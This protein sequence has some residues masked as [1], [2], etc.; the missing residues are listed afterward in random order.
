MEREKLSKKIRFEVFKRDSF[1]CQYCG[2]KAPD[3]VLEVDH[4][5]PVAEGGKNDIFNLITSCFDCNRGKGKRPLT[6]QDELKK[7]QKMLEELNERKEQLEML[8]QWKKGLEN[9]EDE[10]VDNIEQ[11]LSDATDNHFSEY[12][13]NDCKRLIKKYGFEEVYEST[14]ISIQQYYIPNDKESITKT[15]NYIGRI[16]SVRK[17]QRENPLAKDINYLCKIGTNRFRF[18]N[19]DRIKAFLNKHYEAEDYLDLRDIFCNGRNWSDIMEQLYQYY[20]VE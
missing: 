13:R 18:F 3:V 17:T 16:C 15:F 20:G 14:K 10:M 6:Q 5:T 9:L 4:I 2:R 1:T 19:K 11:L 8:L 12:G 7:Q